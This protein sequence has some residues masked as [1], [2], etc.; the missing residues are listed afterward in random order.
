MTEWKHKTVAQILRM[1]GKNIESME[2]K[3]KILEGNDNHPENKCEKCGGR[4]I[5]WHADSDV[6]NEVARKD[7]WGI[8][9]PICFVKLAEK[10]GIIPTAWKL[11]QEIK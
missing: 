3:L 8:L 5:T 2:R 4:N 1:L 7:G 10:K 6:W 11:S 9:C